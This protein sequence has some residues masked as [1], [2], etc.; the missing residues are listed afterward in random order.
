MTRE[1]LNKKEKN[2]NF[3]SIEK[4]PRK[5]KWLGV[6]ISAIFAIL[7]IASTPFKPTKT[8]EIDIKITATGEKNSQSLGSEVW[9]DLKSSSILLT[10]TEKE[11][12]NWEIRNGQLLSYE[13]QP[14]TI[15]SK[16]KIEKDEKIEFIKHPYSGIAK[17]EI[18]GIE[19]KVDLYAESGGVYSINPGEFSE[20]RENKKQ[21]LTKAILSFIPVFILL[22]ILYINFSTKKIHTPYTKNKNIDLYLYALFCAPSLLIYSISLI[23][24]WP[25]Q[26]SP[27][28]VSQWHQ[29]VSGVYNDSH[30]V[31]STVFYSIPYYFYNSPSSAALFQLIIFSLVSGFI[32]YEINSWG[33]NKKITLILSIAFPLIL[34]NFLLSTTL[35]K[36]VP[37]SISLLLLTTLTAREIR[38]NLSLKPLSLLA[39]FLTCCLII[40]FRHNGILVTVPYLFTLLIFSKLQKKKI[41]LIFSLHIIFFIVS[42]TYLI[43]IL[44][45]TP[46]SPHYKSIYAIHVIGA[47]EKANIEWDLESKKIISQALPLKDFKES[48]DCKNVVPL[49][50][51]KNIS[52]EFLG[53]NSSDLNKIALTS[54]INHPLIFLEHQLCLSQLTWR[55]LPNNNE[56]LIISPM[57][58]FDS[59]ESRILNL[60]SDSLLPKGLNLTKNINSYF[61][62]E[63]TLLRST[64]YLYFAIFL[65]ICLIHKNK[66]SL[67]LLI[68]PALLN[69]ASIALM[70]GSQ[71]YR[72]IWPTF[73]CS[74]IVI[75]LLIFSIRINPTETN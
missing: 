45:A 44:G 68:M 31:L 16:I 35:W 57:T 38:N 27:D 17:I 46:V 64:I 13:N 1:I 12:T 52:Y 18:N 67:I 48:Y 8:A 2:F 26:M 63:N 7:I 53:K 5:G 36:D 23:I 22:L 58:I 59:E 74:L 41:F 28:S 40:S 25:A 3:S 51:N 15:E 61:S 19:K 75:T 4:K 9:L 14:Q 42:K 69:S 73:I 71:D 70:T 33:C 37:F 50:W 20:F 24:F 49:F 47:M 21:T 72:Y 30:P 11:K 32:F 55:I 10:G 34:P 60:K 56:W 39:I 43:T 65:I 29:I 66:K 62:F 6:T 54:I